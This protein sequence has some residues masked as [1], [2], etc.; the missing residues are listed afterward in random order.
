MG[1]GALVTLR[2]IIRQKVYY[3]E[4]QIIKTIEGNTYVL[5]GKHINANLLL[6]FIQVAHFC[7]KYFIFM[8]YSYFL[9]NYSTVPSNTVKQILFSIPR[10]L[11]SKKASKSADL[12]LVGKNVSTE[13]IVILQI[14]IISIPRAILTYT[15]IHFSRENYIV[16]LYSNLGFSITFNMLM[17]IELC[18]C[19]PS[20]APP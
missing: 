17:W 8:V 19:T 7:S 5:E 2:L 6:L 13:V 16:L 10:R 20:I 1:W 18:Y 9:C 4:N 14:V 11:Q 3:I 15:G 12:Y